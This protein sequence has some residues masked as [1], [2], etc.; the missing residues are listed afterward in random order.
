MG[1]TYDIDQADVFKNQLFQDPEV[2]HAAKEKN[3]LIKR[4]LV[5]IHFWPPI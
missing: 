1:Q 5:P 3:T 4:I 2:L